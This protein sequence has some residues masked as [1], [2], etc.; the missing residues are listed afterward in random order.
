MTPIQSQKSSEALDAIHDL[1]ISLMNEEN[2]ER[3][4]EG[5]DIIQTIARYKGLE[6]VQ[7]T[8]DS[9]NAAKDED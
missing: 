7:D 5:L 6:L 2:P 4:A 1:A 3:L 8:L 9:F